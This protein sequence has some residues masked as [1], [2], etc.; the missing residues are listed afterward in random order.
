MKFFT[1]VIVL[2]YIL[3]VNIVS[4]NAQK[5]NDSCTCKIIS[6]FGSAG[7]SLP[8]KPQKNNATIAGSI[9]FAYL[10]NIGNLGVDWQFNIFILPK[11]I[12]PSKSNVIALYSYSAKYRSKYYGSR[13]FLYGASL[14]FN[15][16]HV[17]EGYTN[18]K[19]T[20]VGASIELGYYFALTKIGAFG[21]STSYQYAKL[22]KTDFSNVSL[23]LQ[24]AAPW[25]SW[26]RK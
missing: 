18:E 17:T 19:E 8:T 25:L 5:H 21:L 6:F 7:S 1:R 26:K 3:L 2:V 12:D 11:N 24:Y 4:T 23:K 9:G 13:R 20:G 15:E 16:T 14:D 10:T 22:S